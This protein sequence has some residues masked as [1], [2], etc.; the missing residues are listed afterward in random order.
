MTLHLMEKPSTN[1]ECYQRT[2]LKMCPHLRLHFLHS[3]DKLTSLPHIHPDQELEIQGWTALL[4]TLYSNGKALA[5]HSDPQLLQILLLTFRKRCTSP[6]LIPQKR[7]STNP[8][9]HRY[10]KSPFLLARLVDPEEL[11]GLLFSSLAFA[12]TSA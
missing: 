5:D 11:L 12:C 3:G 6:I 2:A 10:L 4:H 1:L 8:S 7:S 9:E